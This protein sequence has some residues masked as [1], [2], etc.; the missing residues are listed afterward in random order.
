MLQI[1]EEAFERAM[2]GLIDLG[3]GKPVE[4]VAQAAL[5]LLREG[6]LRREDEAL[7]LLEEQ[8]FLC[9]TDDEGVADLGP[10]VLQDAP[11][12]NLAAPRAGAIPAPCLRRD[13][14]VQAAP[15]E[16]PATPAAKPPPEPRPRRDVEV[17]VGPVPLPVSPSWAEL[18]QG[19]MEARAWDL[20]ARQ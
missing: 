10:G 18:E 8:P 15:V 6:R 20:A 19:L 16:E 11:S 14:G 9:D 4:G 13:V 5:H 1:P 3:L 2:A 7:E 12:E 17:Q